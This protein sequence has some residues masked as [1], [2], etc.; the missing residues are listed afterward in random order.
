LDLGRIVLDRDE[1]IEPTGSSVITVFY[2]DWLEMCPISKF[3]HKELLVEILANWERRVEE[4][5]K[6]S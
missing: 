2:P 1:R 5:A 3:E 4:G 6:W